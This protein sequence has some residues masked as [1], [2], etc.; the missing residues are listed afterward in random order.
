MINKHYRDFRF[1]DYK[2]QFLKGNEAC[3]VSPNHLSLH[4]YEKN[5]TSGI[6]V[7]TF[8]IIKTILITTVHRSG[9]F[10]SSLPF[11]WLYALM[12]VK[13]HNG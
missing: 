4:Q 9:V 2:T 13:D 3:K 12:F 11:L 8:L 10:L 1:S 6:A 7:C 5:P